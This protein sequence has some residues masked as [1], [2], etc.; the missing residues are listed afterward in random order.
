M[1]KGSTAEMRRPP[2]AESLPRP[3]AETAVAPECRHHWVIE[4]PHGA[5][6]SG[7]CKRCGTVREFRNA[8]GDGYWEDDSVSDLGRWGR[9]S[10]PTRV[11][12]DD[13][14]VA[15]APR[16]QPALAL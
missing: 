6:S 9:R 7:V 10:T 8:A 3:G 16:K 1:A 14:E 15:T 4:S 11:S 12:D 13:D 2:Q 5:T